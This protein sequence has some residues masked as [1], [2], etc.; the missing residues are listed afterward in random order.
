MNVEIGTEAG[1]FL[2]WEFVSNFRY[3]VFAVWVGW[4]SF[5][6]K[7]C[8]GGGGAVGFE[9]NETRAKKVLAYFHMF[10]LRSKVLS[11]QRKEG[12]LCRSFPP[13]HSQH[14]GTK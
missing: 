2:F 5:W 4:W 13:F 9:L 10:L 6:L 1:Q 3:C 14:F 8:W 7:N 11:K 12:K